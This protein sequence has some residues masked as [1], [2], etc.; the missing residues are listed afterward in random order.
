MAGD[1]LQVIEVA[2]ADQA[3][4][5]GAGSLVGQ[6]AA[7]H[8]VHFQHFGVGAGNDRHFR[9]DARFQG[10]ADLAHAL[11]DRDQ[12]GGLASE[13]RRQQR[14]LDG[15][16]GH[17]GTLQLDH[18]AHGVQRIAIAM[19]GVGDHRQAGDATDA[20]GLFDEFAQGDEREIGRRQN[21]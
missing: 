8:V 21:L 10:R 12:V 3:D 14:V 13:L 5:V 18:G 6:G 9:I 1:G 17:A 2:D 20:R 19:V 4:A 15:Q 11:L 7:D 16:R